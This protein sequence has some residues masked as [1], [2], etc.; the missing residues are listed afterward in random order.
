MKHPHKDRYK[1]C[2]IYLFIF[3]TAKMPMGY[4]VFTFSTN[5]YNIIMKL[6]FK[7]RTN[8]KQP[9]NEAILCVV[10]RV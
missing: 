8:S 7:T 10:F 6:K 5:T 2:Y 3:Q 1:Q 4:L 9:I